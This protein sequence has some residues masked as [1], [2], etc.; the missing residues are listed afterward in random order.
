MANTLCFR[1]IAR[2]LMLGA[3]IQFGESCFQR[4]GLSEILEGNNDFA[5][6][7]PKTG[8]HHFRRQI[9][10]EEPLYYRDSIDDFL[11]LCEKSVRPKEK[12]VNY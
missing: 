10:L 2:V 5:D 8:D 3:F 9:V 11:K 1:K 7:D 6:E 12:D 4:K